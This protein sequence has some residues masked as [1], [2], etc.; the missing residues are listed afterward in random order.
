[1]PIRYNIEGQYRTP[2]EI[3]L[4]AYAR[5]EGL[6]PS[7]QK[8]YIKSLNRLFA[9]EDQKNKLM[10]I[11]APLIG[12]LML[13]VC[14]WIA[15]V[16]PNPSLFQTGVFWMLL[17]LGM[18]ISAV[19]IAGFFEFRY[20]NAIK[21]S[22]GFAIW[23]VMFF[24]VPKIMTIKHESKDHIVLEI[25]PKD[26][27]HLETLLV[28]FDPNSSDDICSFT[29]E[30]LR[31]YWGTSVEEKEFVNY[32]LPDG[33]ILGNISCRDIK[34]DTIMMISDSAVAYFNNKRGAYQYFL[35]KFR[36]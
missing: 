24:Y 28:E 18:A 5:G 34:A 17:S 15:F 22:S 19:L 12:I 25:V 7:T 30:S 20:E 4:E 31:K 33:M 13:G 14:I 26:T 35:K 32:R 1:M 29:A 9:M 11:W 6:S 8:G 21:A 23:V 27:L 2:V 36:Q 16:R 3:R 10:R